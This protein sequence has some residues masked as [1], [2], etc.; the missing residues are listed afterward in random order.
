[1]VR[2]KKSG[3]S[4]RVWVPACSTG[5]EAYS[6]AMLILAELKAQTKHCLL[7]VF[8]TDIN[9]E[10][11]RIARIGTFPAGIAAHI[12][13]EHLEQFFTA[14]NHQYHV[15]QDLRGALVFGRHN[16]I[17]DP[18]FSQLDLISCRNVLIY[19]EPEVQQKVLQLFD[20]ALSAKGY[21]FLGS[22][23]SLGDLSPRFR[24]LSK[25]W[26]IFAHAG[27]A[28]VKALDLPINSPS[29][30]TTRVPAGPVKTANSI[31][32]PRQG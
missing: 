32:D 12:P 2:A 29:L 23:E 1:M 18:P 8:A 10:T 21:L 24:E 17:A 13:K 5:E 6:V 7:M 22:A 11:L 3:E 9:E 26:R 30:I 28:P 20:F 14:D 16:L 19:L 4:I 31:G 25:K 27:M 15:N